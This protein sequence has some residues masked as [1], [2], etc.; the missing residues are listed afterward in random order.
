MK[1]ITIAEASDIATDI[2][3]Q[4]KDKLDRHALAIF[5][6]NKAVLTVIDELEDGLIVIDNVKLAYMDY[7]NS[8]ENDTYRQP[9][10]VNDF[11]TANWWTIQ[12]IFNYL[13]KGN[14]MLINQYES[15]LNQIIDSDEPD[16]TGLSNIGVG[17]GTLRVDAESR[18]KVKKYP[19]SS[20]YFASNLSYAVC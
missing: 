7:L 20:S 4:I 6:I 5:I 11:E 15:N 13:M 9:T 10:Y 8:L 1:S 14:E 19:Y 17:I 3:Y 18:L 12:L 16:F 2:L